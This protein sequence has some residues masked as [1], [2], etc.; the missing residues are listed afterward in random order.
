MSE[1]NIPYLIGDKLGRDHQF[2]PTVSRARLY[3]LYDAVSPIEQLRM[4]MQ[5]PIGVDLKTIQ[6]L[7]WR[8]R[9][10]SVEASGW[11]MR[12]MAEDVPVLSA[13]DLAIEI[14]SGATPAFT[15]RR[16]RKNPSS[17]VPEDISDELG[18][19]SH[20]DNDILPGDKIAPARNIGFWKTLRNLGTSEGNATW[21][22][23]ALVTYDYSFDIPV[24]LT[25]TPPG[26]YNHAKFGEPGSGTGGSLIIYMLFDYVIY[27]QGLFWPQI[28]FGAGAQ[29]PITVT[30]RIPPRFVT[31]PP[32]PIV[33][34]VVAFGGAP[35]S[36]GELTINITGVG[37]LIIPIVL[38]GDDTPYSFTD[39][40]V[41]R[42]LDGSLTLEV[43]SSKFWR[44]KNGAGQ[45]V[46]NADTGAQEHSPIG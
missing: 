11:S 15:F 3:E 45:N 14:V 25:G 30:G 34:P 39:A 38:F 7:M 28:F 33:D 19:L 41:E 32:N 42:T 20:W 31:F 27:D 44:F 22:D 21:A 1:W 26:E 24:F 36:A 18:I 29:L 13:D 40:T 43:N 23:D 8:V 6:A 35:E 17:G 16:Q 10:W 9:E 5:Y 37:S 12:F 4:E 46:Y 2:W